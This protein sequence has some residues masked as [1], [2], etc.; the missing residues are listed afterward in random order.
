M[1]HKDTRFRNFVPISMNTFNSLELGGFPGWTNPEDDLAVEVSLAARVILYNDEEH[2]F[3]EVIGQIMAATGC[4][5]DH[6]EVLTYE[7]HSRGMAIVFEGE[8]TEC[9]RVSAIL[10]EI[11]LHTQVAM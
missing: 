11:A 9:L 8:M 10:E 3:D 4:S 2:T 7:V 1:N 6:A 5:Y